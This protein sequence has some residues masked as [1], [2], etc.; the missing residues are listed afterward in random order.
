MCRLAFDIGFDQFLP[1]QLPTGPPAPRLTARSGPPP[2]RGEDGSSTGAS[3]APL[4]EVKN[5]VPAAL[6]K[7]FGD[8]VHGVHHGSRTGGS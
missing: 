6:A 1:S 7:C 3:E 4:D 5:V 8:D 2:E